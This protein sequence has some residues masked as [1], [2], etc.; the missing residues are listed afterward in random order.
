M[1]ERWSLRLKD[2]L[3]HR[4]TFVSE[5]NRQEY[6]QAVGRDAGKTIVVRNAVQVERFVSA[7]RDPSFRRSFGIPE[8]APIV[9]LVARLSEQRKGAGYFIDMA[10]QVAA[11]ASDARFVIVGEGE[12]RAGLE[13]QA[14]ALGLG[15][16]L[17]FTGE[18]SDV[19]SLLKDMTLFV[20]PSLAEGASYVLLEAMAAGLPVVV[21]PSGLVPEIIRDGE[22][23]LIVPFR[24]AAALAGAVVRLLGDDALRTKIATAGQELARR[25]D[26]EAMVDGYVEVYEQAAA[27]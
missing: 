20:Q 12:L 21:T 26:V 22:N 27:R 2:R 17:V 16:R 4:L 3:L 19:P 5:G 8:Q 15:D 25:F 13:A 11:Q 1:L 10:A 9:G 14:A 24:D 18:R 6:V 7:E 23:G